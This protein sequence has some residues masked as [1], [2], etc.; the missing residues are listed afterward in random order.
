[1]LDQTF[2]ARTLHKL[3]SVSELVEF[4]LGGKPDKQLEEL[5]KIAQEINKDEFELTTFKCFKRNGKLVYK[6]K[7]KTD[8]FAIK[9]ANDNVKKIFGVS[10]ADRQLLVNQIK[11]LLEETSPFHIV[12]VDISSFFESIDKKR[13][14]NKCWDNPILS[15]VTKKIIGCLLEKGQFK[16]Q[17]GLP[18]GL[19]ISATLSE[20]YLQD[21][22]KYIRGLEG[23]Y[24]SARYVDDIIIFCIPSAGDTQKKVEEYVVDMGLTINKLKTQTKKNKIDKYPLIIDYLGYRFTKTENS[25]FIDIAPSKIKKIKTRIIK[26]F[27]S[28]INDKNFPLLENRLRF[29][30]G[31]FRLYSK[32]KIEGETLKTGIYYN[33]SELTPGAESLHSLDT[34]LVSLIYSKHS[35]LGI[36]IRGTLTSSQRR[37]LRK[38]SFKTGFYKRITHNFSYTDVLSIRE[39]WKDE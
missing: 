36:K 35:S 19:S 27:I 7:S 9:K 8:H 31:N 2:S 6:A 33:Y 34:F 30:T 21:L 16:T 25:V 3:C 37:K 23:I 14:I 12:K 13:L 38:Y 26:S 39:C 17:L 5:D 15:H 20:L 29:L 10:S 24:Y 32:S 22:D 11:V 1:M 18:R 4:R 28:Y